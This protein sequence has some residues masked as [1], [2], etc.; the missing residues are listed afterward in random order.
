MTELFSTTTLTE[1]VTIFPHELNHE[2]NTHVLKK[3][4]DKLTGENGHGSCTQYGYIKSVD[5]VLKKIPNP[6]VSDSGRGEC[7]IDV[8]VEVNS[9]LPVIGQEIECTISAIDEHIGESIS[10][11][12]P[13]FILII[14]D[15]DDVLR[16]NQTVK[17][18][19][20]DFQLK[21]GDD[22]INLVATYL[23]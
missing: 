22:I 10:F 16:V 20:E 18:R 11:Q 4:R 1:S 6:K 9:Y 15:T 2:L 17:V 5:R 21:H 14:N 13:I 23:P 7:I 3:I 19:I 12:L 8:M